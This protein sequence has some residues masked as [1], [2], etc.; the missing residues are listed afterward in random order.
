MNNNA[1]QEENALAARMLVSALIEY[2]EPDLPDIRRVLT[3]ALS[4]ARD[5]IEGQSEIERR[6][7][8]ALTTAVGIASS[9]D[10]KPQLTLVPRE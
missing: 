3:K 10:E 9:A 4:T 8:V 6:Y 2:L 1:D 7:K 5:S